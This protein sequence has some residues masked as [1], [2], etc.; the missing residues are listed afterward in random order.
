MQEISSVEGIKNVI[1][2][3]DEIERSSEIVAIKK[4]TFASMLKKKQDFH[5]VKR[6]YYPSRRT[7]NRMHGTSNALQN[8]KKNSR[9]G[10]P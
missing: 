2:K 4:E 7:D 1:K 8:P 3:M 6:D 9:P 10:F 5:H